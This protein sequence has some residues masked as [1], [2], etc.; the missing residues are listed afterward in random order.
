M[1]RSNFLVS[2]FREGEMRSLAGWCGHRF[3]WTADDSWEIKVKQVN[4]LE[5]DQSLRNPSIIL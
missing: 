5:C 3:T 1:V 2:E 4:L